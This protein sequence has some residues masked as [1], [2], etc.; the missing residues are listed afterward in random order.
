MQEQ[1]QSSSTTTTTTSAE[2]TCCTPPNI[3]FKNPQLK[4]KLVCPNTGHIYENR[5]GVWV[6]TGR[7]VTDLAG[8]PQERGPGPRDTVIDPDAAGDRPSQ[9]AQ[10][11]TR[12]NLHGRP[13]ANN[14]GKGRDHATIPAG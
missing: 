8:Q 10:T 13:F 7:T 3:L 1:R 9:V 6:D 4:D 12:V 5:G 2:C 14:S 11:G